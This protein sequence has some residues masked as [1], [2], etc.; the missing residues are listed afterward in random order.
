MI[1]A[2]KVTRAM[3]LKTIVL[4]GASGGRVKG[5]AE[6]CICVPAT[7]VDKIQELHLPIYHSL[8]SALE[9]ALFGENA[10]A[11]NSTDM[12]A[13]VAVITPQLQ[14]KINL[15]VFDFDGVFTDKK[16]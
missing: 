10:G 2:L 3:G 15:V 7:R 11:V 14:E 9:D 8:C 16:V 6:I 5:L 12:P 13:H 4:T 1:N